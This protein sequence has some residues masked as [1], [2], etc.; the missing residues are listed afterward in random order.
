MYLRPDIP[1]IPFQFPT[2]PESIVRYVQVQMGVS[3]SSLLPICID[4]DNLKR[5]LWYSQVPQSCSYKLNGDRH[6]FV[7]KTTAYRRDNKFK[8]QVL[9]KI[10]HGGKCFGY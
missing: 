8:A 5:T 7:P 6:T 9:S 3:L 1:L 10:T 2:T 4:V